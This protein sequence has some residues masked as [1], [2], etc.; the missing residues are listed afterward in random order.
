MELTG[1]P[2]SR[3]EPVILQSARKK[4][5]CGRKPRDPREAL[6]GILW[7]LRGGAPWKDFA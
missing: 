7:T 3:I 6:N 4:D 1:K 2:W 5:S